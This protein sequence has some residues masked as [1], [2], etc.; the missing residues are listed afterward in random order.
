MRFCV[1]NNHVLAKQNIHF[2]QP[3]FP[4]TCRR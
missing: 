4:E 3:D 1:E 2:N